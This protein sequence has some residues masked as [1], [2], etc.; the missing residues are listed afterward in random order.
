[1]VK[2]SLWTTFECKRSSLLIHVVHAKKRG[3]TTIFSFIVILHRIFGLCFTRYLVFCGAC[4]DDR[5]RNLLEG[6]FWGLSKCRHLECYP[7]LSYVV[8][9]EGN[10]ILGLL[11]GWNPFCFSRSPFLLDLLKSIGD[12][13]GSFFQSSCFF[14]NFTSLLRAH[15]E[16]RGVENFDRILTYR[17]SNHLFWSQI[18][19]LNP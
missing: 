2:S 14:V 8:Q 16:P 9:L 18:N 5:H 17:N 3:K 7:S 12:I 11:K 19:M 13:N 4:L 6:W 1:M 15:T 10:V